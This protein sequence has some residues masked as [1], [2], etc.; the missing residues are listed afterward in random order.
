M[1]L[2]ESYELTGVRLMED[3]GVQVVFEGRAASRARFHVTVGAAAH[4]DGQNLAVRALPVIG[5]PSGIQ[6]TRHTLHLA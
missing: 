5:G 6:I 3:V 2:S 1:D 4:A